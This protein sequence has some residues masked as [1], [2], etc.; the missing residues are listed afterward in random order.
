MRPGAKSRGS[1][2]LHIGQRRLLVTSQ[3]FTLRDESRTRFP[4][5]APLPG[6]AGSVKEMPARQLD[7]Q[8]ARI[9][10]GLQLFKASA[11]ESLG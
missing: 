3:V 4:L 8:G 9:V 5:Q 6:G 1:R 2:R 10:T 11:N 7:R